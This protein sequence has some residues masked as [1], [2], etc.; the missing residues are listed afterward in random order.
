M[1]NILSRMNN[2]LKI[3]DFKEEDLEDIQKSFVELRQTDKEFS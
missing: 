3:I 2:K 1:K